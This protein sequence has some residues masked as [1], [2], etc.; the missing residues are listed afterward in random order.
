MTKPT[1]STAL[2]ASTL[3]LTSAT[4]IAQQSS[5]FRQDEHVLN[6]AAHPEDDE[7]LAGQS[8]TVTLDALGEGISATDLSSAS[9]RMD[10]GLGSAYPPPG[11]VTG[12]RFQ[13]P[14]T[15]SWDPERSRGTYNVYR[16]LLSSLPGGYGDCH[17]SG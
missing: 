16:G 6:L 8:F 15:L 9:Y 5:S 4:A 14:T 13:D 2:R 7:V 12:V 17:E 11:E 10:G 1:I 3:V